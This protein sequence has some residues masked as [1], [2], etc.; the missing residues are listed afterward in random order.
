M[1]ELNYAEALPLFDACLGKE[2]VFLSV[3][4]E[5]P[6]TMTISWGFHGVMWGLPMIVAMVRPT[7]YT[8]AHLVATGEFT[9]SIPTINPLKQELMFVGAA[10]GR[11]VDKFS[12]HGL[13]AVPALSVSAPVVK[14]CGL[15]FECVV[16]YIDQMNEENVAPFG[17][18]W[19]AKK[20]FHTLFFGEI[21]SCYTTD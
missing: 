18:Q 12:G 15:H 3:A 17:S 7:R 10:S 5:K 9:V 19:Y 8:F 1:K 11:D 6:N 13:T 20:D 21:V 14:E 16:R 2:G 4:G